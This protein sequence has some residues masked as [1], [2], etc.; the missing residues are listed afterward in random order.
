M[1]VVTAKYIGFC[2]YRRSYQVLNMIPRN[3]YVVTDCETEEDQK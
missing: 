2:V 1:L 3:K